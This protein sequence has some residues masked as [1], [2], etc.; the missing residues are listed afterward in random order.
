MRHVNLHEAKANLSALVR[1][2]GRG[3][4]VVITNRGRPVARLVPIAKPPSPRVF[5]SARGL[6]GWKDMSDEAIAATIDKALAPMAQA[7][8]EA[9]GWE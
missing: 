3:G 5:G 8:A 7:E 2:V 6:P 9:E 4:E 1:E